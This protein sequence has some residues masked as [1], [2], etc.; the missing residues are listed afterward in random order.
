MLLFRIN[1]IIFLKVWY[2]KILEKKKKMTKIPMLANHWAVQQIKKRSV[3][4]NPLRIES[5]LLNN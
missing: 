5:N 3:I 2:N 1:R 4:A